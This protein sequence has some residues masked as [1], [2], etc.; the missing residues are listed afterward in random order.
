MLPFSAFRRLFCIL[1]IIN[2]IHAKAQTVPAQSNTPP[3]PPSAAPSP[4]PDQT[5]PADTTRTRSWSLHFQQTVITQW[6]ANFSAPYTGEYSLRPRESAKTSLTSTVFIGRQ[7]WRGA[8]IYFNPELAGGSGLSAARGIAGFT[9]GE[10][11]RIGDPAPKL[12][13]ARLFLRQV[14]ALDASTT[15]TDDAPNQIA[16]AAPTRFFALNVGKFSLSDYFDQNSYSHDPRSQFM[17][18][19]LMSNG[20]WDYPA[21]TRGYTVGA[22]G[23]YVTPS[24]ALRAATSLV[25]LEANGPI[26]NKHYHTAHSETLELSR[27]YAV[28]GRAGTVRMLGFRTVA[29]MGDYHLAMLRDDRDITATRVNGRTKT[30]FG[31]NAEQELTEQIGAFARL[32]YND[33]RRETW[34]FT[35]IDRSL[36]AG[37]SSTGATWQRPDDRLGLAVVGNGLSTAHRDYLA[38]GGHGFIIG[39]GRLTYAPEMIAEAYYSL[40]FPKQ[41]ATVSPDYQFVLHPAY[42]R[43]R[44]PVHVVAVRLH[45]AF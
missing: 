11:F 35:E 27:T 9:N 39:D 15:P 5:T 4:A 20:A 31:L 1:L 30:G 44:G 40:N 41:H 17:N 22:V 16:G 24:F 13:L 38:A 32:S 21:N 6:H 42:N 26:L 3:A 43:D 45:V 14:W 25:P 8:S 19:G 37:L 18:W 33:G 34:A 28:G 2:A 36:S 10:T 7:L 29:D 12:Y 23:E